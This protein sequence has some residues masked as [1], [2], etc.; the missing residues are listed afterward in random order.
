VAARRAGELIE[1]RVADSGMGISSDMLPHVF[2]MFTQERQAL[3]RSHGGLGLGLTIVKRL[4]EL[5]GGTV[6]AHSD[7]PGRGSEFVI[8][9]PVAAT[10]AAARQIGAGGVDSWQPVASR[11]ILVVDDNVDA[12]HT[13]AEALALAGHETRLAFDGP[14]AL[15][16]AAEF[17]PDAAVLDLGLPLMDGYEL[18][19]QLV[20]MQ[21]IRPVLVAVT[22]YGQVSDKHRTRAAGFDAHIVKPVDIP[23]LLKTLQELLRIESTPSR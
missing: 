17:Q 21:E 10:P 9:L 12:A 5:H 3:D 13:M 6:E 19:Q 14:A 7:G 4:I 8:R 16:I 23:G 11:R 20:A 15:A 22:G 2:D 1:L 18:A